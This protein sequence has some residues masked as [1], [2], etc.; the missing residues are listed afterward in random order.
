MINIVASNWIASDQLIIT[1]INLHHQTNCMRSFPIHRHFF[2]ANQPY[3]PAP[4]KTRRTDRTPKPDAKSFKKPPY[5]SFKDQY[6]KATTNWW[7]RKALLK[8]LLDLMLAWM[9]TTRQSRY[10]PSKKSLFFVVLAC[11][12]SFSWPFGQV[13]IPKSNKFLD[14]KDL[15]LQLRRLVQFPVRQVEADPVRQRLAEAAIV[16]AVDRGYNDGLVT[17]IAI[18]NKKLLPTKWLFQ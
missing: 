8:Y 1:P 12:G 13:F 9:P 10:L 7:F 16:R 11:F 14:G 6:S 2:I 4:T 5:S 3:K 18:V 17:L 15:L